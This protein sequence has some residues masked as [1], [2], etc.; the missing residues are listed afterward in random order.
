VRFTSLLHQ[1]L[2]L[3][4]T[5]VVG[6]HFVEDGLE[7]DVAP[8]WRRPR[9]SSCG[10]TCRGYD[11]QRGRRWRHLDAA[12]MKLYLRYDTRRVDCVRCGVTVEH[13]PWA[14]VSSWFTR[15]FEN[16]V[17]YLAQRSDKTTVSKLMRVAWTTVGDIIQR[18]VVR[19]QPVDPLDNLTHIGVD[20]LSYRKHHEYVTIVVDHVRGKVVWAHRGK[21]ADT[22]KLFFAA[23]GAERLAK[24][25]A[26]S[27]DMSA[28]YIKAVT[29]A[30]PNATIV[31]DRF[32]VQRLAHDALDE[33]RR[34]EVREA[35]T[36]PSRAGLKGTRWATQKNP[37]N[38]TGVEREKLAML[39]LTNRRLYTAYLLKESMAAI[40]DRRQVHVARVKLDEWVSWAKHS[41]LAPFV[42]VAATVRRHADGILAYVRTRLSNGRTEALNGKARTITRRSYGLHSASA[43]IALL[44]LCCAGIELEPVTLRPGSAH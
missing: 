20:E 26:V 16:H 21:N 5:R 28:A 6:C 30:A 7:V 42:R 4:Y 35:P 15:P 34:A 44:K 17:G 18:V 38:M 8:S 13:L 31:F 33:V 9:C 41:K 2:G 22:L 29:E 37:W 3:E 32:H 11:R 12:G 23:L 10:Y 39:P 43:L 36:A 19:H 1:L 27:I 40:L 14:D 25:A 24:L